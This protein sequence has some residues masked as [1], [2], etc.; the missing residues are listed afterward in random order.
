[1]IETSTIGADAIA[2]RL[3][4]HRPTPEQRAV[5][6]APLEPALVVAGAGSGK[7]ETMAFRVLWLLA[8]GLV[9]A[10]QVLGLTFTRKAAGE[11]QQRIRSRVKALADVGLAPSYDEFDPPEVSTYNAFANGIYRDWAS[12][13]GREGNGV[14]LGEA[15]AWQLARAVVVESTDPALG[16][17]DVGVDWITQLVLSLAGDLGEHAADPAAV[18]AMTAE[19]GAAL[20]AL[21]L[22]GRGAYADCMATATKPARTL[23]VLL[24]LVARFDERKRAL[25]AVQ[26]ADQVSLALEIL[27]RGPRVAADYRDR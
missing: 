22:G 25:G 2:D 14:V 21:P 9:T 19:Y 23:P 6:E 18:R 15:S 11:L 10:P 20:D 16:D 8:N 7:T 5:I 17:L 3:G 26:Y 12:L 24:D 27:R 4:L 13:I 1:V